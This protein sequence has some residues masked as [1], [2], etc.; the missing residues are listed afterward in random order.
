MTNNY[1]SFRH[2]DFTWQE[3]WRTSI[4]SF[5]A[6]WNNHLVNY[7]PLIY[8]YGINANNIVFYIFSRRI[9]II[10]YKRLTISGIPNEKS[11]WNTIYAILCRNVRQ[12]VHNQFITNNN[13]S[14]HLWWKE[15]LLNYQKV[16]KYYEHDSRKIIPELWKTKQEW[17]SELHYIKDIYLEIWENTFDDKYTYL[18]LR[19]TEKWNRQVLWQ[20]VFVDSYLGLYW[21]IIIFVTCSDKTRYG[22]E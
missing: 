16:S 17:K 11:K 14:F 12:L 20:K 21:Y 19:V 15:N 22:K 9:L 2:E 6:R 1:N 4:Y 8:H 3:I 13:S 5:K 10:S 18:L 7:F